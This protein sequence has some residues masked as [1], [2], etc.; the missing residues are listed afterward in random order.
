MSLSKVFFQLK[1]LVSSLLI[2]S[3]ILAITPLPQ[4]RASFGPPAIL[5]YQGRLTN[6]SGDLLGGSGT[7]YYFKFSIWDNATAGSGNQLWPASSPSS[8]AATVRQGV[9]N[10]NIGD[11]ENGFPHLLDLDFSDNEYYYL[12]IEA[13]T[14]S[15]SGFETLTPRPLISASAFAKLSAGVSSTST[16]SSF[17]T[18][19][20]F[21]GATQASFEATT[22]GSIPLAVRAAPGQTADLLQIQEGNDGVNK[23]IVDSGFRVGVGTSSLSSTLGL[24]G[25]GVEGGAIFGNFLTA[26][27]FTA[28]ST[29]ATSTFKGGINLAREAGNVGIGT[30]TPFA[31]LSVAGNGYF[32]GGLSVGVSATTTDGAIRANILHSDTQIVAK[33]LVSCDTIDT[34]AS[35]V[36][37]CGSDNTGAGGGISTIQENDSDVVTSATVI[38]FLGADFIVTAPGGAEGDIAIDYT[39]SGITRRSVAENILANWNF[40]DV[41]VTG[42]DLNIGNGLAATSTLSGGYGKL[43][44]GTTSPFAQIAIEADNTDLYG[45][46]SNTP[47]FVI[48]DS[49]T[50]SSL[51]VVSGVT[52]YIGIGTNTPG[53]KL[54][55]GGFANIKGNLN[56]AATSTAT[57]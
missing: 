43:G 15:G 24:Y 53:T 36:L 3:V 18:T 25:L 7:T 33:N 57:S 9:F 32:R 16:P 35:G 56:I 23:F 2:L 10:V 1:K 5:G 28:T 8:V 42:S 4:A 14:A 19:T 52:G 22:T 37:K 30:S 44:F 55:V 39:N 45:A 17:G 41:F 49:G 50:S 31:L 47:I 51:F 46:G 26:S 13:S 20:Q 6:S 27:Y 48:G 54:D 12:Q 34:D 29:T 11:T 40:L 38:D 21:T